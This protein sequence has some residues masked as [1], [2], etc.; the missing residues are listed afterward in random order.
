MYWYS[1]YTYCLK[2]ELAH[3]CVR[4]STHFGLKVLRQFYIEN[5]KQK[6]SN[7]LKLLLNYANFWWKNLYDK[8]SQNSDYSLLDLIVFH[9]LSELIY[10]W[11]ILILLALTQVTF[12]NHLTLCY[13]SSRKISFSSSS[14]IKMVIFLFIHL[15]TWNNSIAVS[16]A[17]PQVLINIFFIFAPSFIT[18]IWNRKSNINNKFR[19]IIVKIMIMKVDIVKIYSIT[20]PTITK[21]CKNIRFY[22]IKVYIITRE[23][24]FQF[25]KHFVCNKLIKKKH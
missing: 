10:F 8:N 16:H 3:F 11:V 14:A 15:P 13:F 6:I 4:V 2:E 19:V 22:I 24:N 18:I 21:E 17:M 7:I 1:Y 23:E 9:F 20:A 12:T 25:F 5:H